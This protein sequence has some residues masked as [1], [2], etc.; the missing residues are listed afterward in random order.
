MVWLVLCI[1]HCLTQQLSP[2]K[3]EMLKCYREMLE[4]GTLKTKNITFEQFVVKK[5]VRSRSGVIVISVV[6]SPG[7]FTCP[8]DCYYCPNEPTQPR[9]Y[10]RF[11]S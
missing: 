8:N 2:S 7:E 1:Y 4:D 6:T 9:S 3:A 10:L 5:M 11:V